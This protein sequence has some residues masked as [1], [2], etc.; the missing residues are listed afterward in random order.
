MANAH[1]IVS[2]S[3]ESPLSELGRHQVAIAAEK[4]AHAN[5]DLVICSPMSRALDTAKT[6]ADSLQYPRG[7]IKVM[8]E[9]KERNLGVL[10][11]KSYAS[12]EKDTGN[13]IFAE[14]VEGVEPIGQFHSRV[15]AAF[16]E[17][18]DTR[19]HKNVL[20]VCHMNVGRMLRVV[21]QNLEPLAMYEIPRLENAKPE[22]LI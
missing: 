15:F 8:A 9:L 19:R 14:T 11:G 7:N 18:T 12:D 21:A 6:V 5:I 13:T 22:R 4:L 16:R 10:E 2:G 3:K 1:K 17:I 20:I